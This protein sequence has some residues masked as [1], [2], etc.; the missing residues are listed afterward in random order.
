MRMY[1]YTLSY[2]TYINVPSSHTHT[3][4]HTKLP[5]KYLAQ[6]NNGSPGV[7]RCPDTRSELLVIDGAICLNHLSPLC[8]DL[9]CEVE[10]DN[11]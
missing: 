10:S 7:G 6:K 4:T 1:A 2:Y 11:L 5:Y 9:K 8:L 3:Q